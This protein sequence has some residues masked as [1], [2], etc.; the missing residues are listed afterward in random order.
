MKKERDPLDILLSEAF[1]QTRHELGPCKI[2]WHR[3]NKQMAFDFMADQVALLFDAQPRKLNFDPALIRQVL[4]GDYKPGEEA[5]E[6]HA[7]TAVML[8]CKFQNPDYGHQIAKRF[9]KRLIKNWRPQQVILVPNYG[10]AKEKESM[11][12]WRAIPC[13]ITTRGIIFHILPSKDT[14]E[15]TRRGL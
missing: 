10:L 12:F 1:P 15:S 14:G 6:F 3:T 2:I 5:I 13:I 7:T 9:V 11:I 4:G 8:D